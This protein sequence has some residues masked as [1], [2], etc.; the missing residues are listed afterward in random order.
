M[1]AFF[2][3]LRRRVPMPV[4][5]LIMALMVIVP[6]GLIIFAIL[7]IVNEARCDLEHNDMHFCI[8]SPDR[9]L[10]CDVWDHAYQRYWNF[11]M[12]CVTKGNCGPHEW[13]AWSYPV[14][15]STP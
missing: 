1:P 12:T 10:N 9:G 4:A 5:V 15:I 7:A 2:A 13:N 6:M 8:W 3:A 14:R 11:N